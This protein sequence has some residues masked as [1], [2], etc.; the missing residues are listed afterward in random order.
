MNYSICQKV[1]ER[2]RESFSTHHNEHHPPTFSNHNWMGLSDEHVRKKRDRS[3]LTFCW[4][5]TCEEEKQKWLI[6]F[7]NNKI[8]WTFDVGL[9]TCSRT[10][11]PLCEV[12]IHLLFV[13]TDPA[14]SVPFLALNVACC[15]SLHCCN[16]LL[17]IVFY[18]IN[19]L[20]L[21]TFDE[22][23]FVPTCEANTRQLINIT[24]G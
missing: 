6:P 13:P 23:L 12:L 14:D 3:Y 21:I 2:N 8:L 7:S 15:A 9:L 4:W 24:A 22:F 11:H 17:L 5:T 10:E 19:L 1:K 16:R 18:T 20:H